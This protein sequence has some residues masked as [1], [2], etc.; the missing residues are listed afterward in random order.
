MAKSRN[1]PR[2]KLKQ[3]DRSAPLEKTLLELAEQSGILN[4]AKLQSSNTPHHD[5]QKA[6]DGGDGEADV[7]VS[8]FGEAI[9]WS[10]TL[11]MG[12]FTLDVLVANQYAIAIEWKELLG[13]VGRAWPGIFSSSSFS[14]SILVL[15]IHQSSN[16]TQSCYFYSIPSIHT[17]T[18][19]SSSHAYR[20]AS[21]ELAIKCCSSQVL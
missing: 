15:H 17:Q 12:Y 16:I 1:D 14:I 11:A 21:G 9:L 10:L 4:N 7:G 8:R 20:N 3:P 6:E 19:L 18:H 13:R 2:I 5:S